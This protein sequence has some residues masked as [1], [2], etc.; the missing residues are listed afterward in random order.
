MT[1]KLAWVNQEQ[2]AFEREMSEWKARIFREGRCH[3]CETPNAE[4]ENIGGWP[5]CANCAIDP[6]EEPPPATAA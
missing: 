5:I 6:P 3:C 1:L 4:Y 2:L